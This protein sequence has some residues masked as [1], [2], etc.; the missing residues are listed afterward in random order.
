MI[1]QRVPSAHYILSDNFAQVI[2]FL[3]AGG[4]RISDVQPNKYL[5]YG[6]RR[7][8][9]TIA[10]ERTVVIRVIMRMPSHGVN[11]NADNPQRLSST[12]RIRGC[13]M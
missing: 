6:M 11:E 4:N 5:R 3:K 10:K 12:S 2:I 13:K 9:N 8:S 7:T 1:A